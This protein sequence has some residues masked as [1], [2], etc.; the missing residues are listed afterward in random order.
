MKLPQIVF[1]ETASG[2]WRW[3]LIGRCGQVIARCAASSA[4]LEQC[5]I[6]VNGASHQIALAM[7]QPSTIQYMPRPYRG[8]GSPPQTPPSSPEGS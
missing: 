6:A 3:E 5:R 8:T 7:E 4:S 1:Y 2:R